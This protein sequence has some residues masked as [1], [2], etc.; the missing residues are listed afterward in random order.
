MPPP[1]K[2]SGA[3]EREQVE[4]KNGE[5]MQVEARE[6]ER[7]QVEE[8]TNPNPN[9]NPNPNPNPNPNQ[10]SSR[11]PPSKRWRGITTTRDSGLLPPSQNHVSPSEAAALVALATAAQRPTPGAPLSTMKER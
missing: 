6:G 10:V 7:V 9:L 3:G 4:E 5:T 2:E 8:P 1:L 11:A